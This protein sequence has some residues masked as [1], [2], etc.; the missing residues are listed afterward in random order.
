MLLS[1][2]FDSVSRGDG[3]K[4]VGHDVI[5]AL[6]NQSSSNPI[7]ANAMNDVFLD[8]RAEQVLNYKLPQSESSK[9]NMPNTHSSQQREAMIASPLTT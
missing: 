3:L 5:T 7:V 4:S 8:K 6:A 1:Q 2:A 9:Q